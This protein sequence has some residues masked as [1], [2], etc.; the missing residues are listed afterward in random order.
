[1]P[2]NVH[3]APGRPKKLFYIH[4]RTIYQG[5][6]CL[7]ITHSLRTDSTAQSVLLLQRRLPTPQEDSL[8]AVDLTQI[9]K[10]GL[11][12]SS[13]TLTPTVCSVLTL[14]RVVGGRDYVP[15]HSPGLL[16]HALDPIQLFPTKVQLPRFRARK[17]DFVAGPGAP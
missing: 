17:T 3:I 7:T 6:Q 1:M 15:T 9:T 13:A 2:K 5:Y 14:Q 8:R 4:D 12:S 10:L 16:H 11:L